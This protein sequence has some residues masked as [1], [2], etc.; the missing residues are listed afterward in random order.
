MRDRPTV[1]VLLLR[2]DNRIL[3]ARFHDPRLNGGRVFWATIGG[4]LDPGESIE[5][6]ARREIREETGLR[7][8]TLGPVVWTDDVVIMTG[9]E[10]WFFHETYVVAHTTS[11]ALAFDGWT[12]LEREVIKDMRWFS[13]PEIGACAEQVYPEVLAEWLP[14]IL[15]C[16]YPETPREIPRQEHERQ[17]PVSSP[18]LNAGMKSDVKA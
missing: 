14:D 13:V 4:G 7:D 11:D 12:D 16:R 15:E 10:P 2:P 9:S 18:G 3:L 6:G 8:V 1:R 5:D 17:A